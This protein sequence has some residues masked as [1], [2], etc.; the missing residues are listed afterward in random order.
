MMKKFTV[1]KSGTSLL[2]VAAMLFAAS[3]CEQVPEKTD[4]KADH[5]WRYLFDG[6]T[7]QGWT[8]ANGSQVGEAWQVINGNLVLTDGGAGD[9]VTADQFA[10]FE[11]EL[12]WKISEGG[13]SGIIYRVAGD[14]APVWMSG[15]E[16]QVLDN[17]AFPNLEKL[18]HSAG[19]VFDMYAPNE[20]EVKPAGE[21]NKTRIRVE[22]GKVEHWLNG[23]MVVSYELWSEDWDTR[24]ANSKFSSYP[25]FAR[26]ES[27]FIAL[28]DHGDKVW[29]RNIRIREL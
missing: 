17:S 2:A 5:Q 20:D 25:D 15:M 3:G 21:F 12:E 16:Y 9:I 7:L 4:L 18:S 14:N 1:T 27:G 28:Q 10:D 13:N 29:Y 8:G 22:D 19:S 24:L 26:S 11:L 6:E 23:N